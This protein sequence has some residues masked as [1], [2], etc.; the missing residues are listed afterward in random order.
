MEG[1]TIKHKKINILIPQLLQQSNKY[2]KVFKDNNKINNIFR[3]FELKSS[4]KLNFFIKESINRYKNM[5]LGNDLNKIILNSENKCKTE[6]NRIL[7]DKFFSNKIIKQ[8]KKNLK[9]YTSDKIYKNLKKAFKLIKASGNSTSR[10]LEKEK[11]DEKFETNK[12][13]IDDKESIHEELTKKELLNKGKEEID[14]VFKYDNNLIERMLEKYRGDVAILQKIG[15]KSPE[16]YASIHKKI[17]INLPKLEM[18]NYAKYEPPKYVEKDIEILQKNTLDKIMPFT[19]YY[20]NNIS[21]KNNKN[22]STNKQKKDLKIKKM[23]KKLML[24]QK[25]ILSPKLTISNNIN[26]NKMDL[27]DTNDVVYKT[28]YKE[29]TA[30]KCIDEKRKILKDILAYDEPKIEDYKTIIKNKFKDIKNKRNKTNYKIMQN[31]KV[32]SMS[33]HDKINTQI[34]NGIIL[35]TEVEKNLFKNLKEKDKKFYKK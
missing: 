4:N 10:L 14:E 12:S 32:E 24:N 5:R 11:N 6:A 35:L 13:I 31:Q 19:K 3:E 7:S 18:I 15:E 25:I 30:P 27:N 33:V 2:K 26:Y 22:K 29:L 34:D 21:I 28:A 23:F 8:E 20:K 9:N 1:N 16:K 17:G